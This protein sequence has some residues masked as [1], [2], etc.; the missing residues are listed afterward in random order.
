[1]LFKIWG[2]KKEEKNLIE[3]FVIS[4]FNSKFFSKYW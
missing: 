3:C 2:F 1:M 4:L